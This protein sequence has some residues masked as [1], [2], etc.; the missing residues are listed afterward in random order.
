[1]KTFYYHTYARVL[2][3]FKWNLLLELSYLQL[4]AELY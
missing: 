4:T 3:K 2:K 1:M